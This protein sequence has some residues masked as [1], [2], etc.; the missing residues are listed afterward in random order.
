MSCSPSTVSP[1]GHSYSTT[2]GRFDLRA[3]RY[4]P[5][6]R[7]PTGYASVVQFFT[8]GNVKSQIPLD[9]WNRIG[10]SVWIGGGDGRRQSGA[11]H[12]EAMTRSTATI[13]PGSR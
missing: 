7:P 11:G 3:W 2:S 4:C 10:R 8:K 13:Q 9:G 5:P 1:W 6:S 12:R